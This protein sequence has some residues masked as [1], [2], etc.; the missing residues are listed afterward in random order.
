[1][2]SNT[3]KD[4]HTKTKSSSAAFAV[5]FKKKSSIILSTPEHVSGAGSVR[6]KER[7]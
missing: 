7:A 3:H 1:M 4:T 2:Y 5:Q 6:K